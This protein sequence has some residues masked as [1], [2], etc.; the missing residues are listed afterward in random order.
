M[1]K[2]ALLSSICAIFFVLSCGVKK[3]P[4]PPQKEKSVTSENQELDPNVS[5]K[6]KKK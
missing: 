2:K 6:K 1:K 4:L 3:D 5:S